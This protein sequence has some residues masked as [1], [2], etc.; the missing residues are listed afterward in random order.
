MMINLDPGATFKATAS[1]AVPG[2]EAPAEVVFEFRALTRKRITGLLILTRLLE[3]NRA[4]R[5]FEFVRLCWRVKRF[6]TVVDMLD[7]FVVGWGGIEPGYSR[8]ALKALL[9]EYPGAHQSI[10]LAFIKGWYE[11]R[12]KN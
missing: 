12:I 7:E 5:L 1:I 4:H 3:K 10:Y 9:G 11:E 6:A 2:K 8:D